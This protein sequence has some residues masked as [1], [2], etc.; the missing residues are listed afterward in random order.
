MAN[1]IADEQGAGSSGVGSG[2]TFGSNPED[3][4]VLLSREIPGRRVERAS[5][6]PVS[7]LKSLHDVTDRAKKDLYEA[8]YIDLGLT[9]NH[10]FSGSPMRCPA[11]MIGGTTTD[12]DFVGSWA[13]V[14][15]GEPTQGKAYFLVQ[16]RGTTVPRG[17][18]RSV[19]TAWALRAARPTLSRHTHQRLF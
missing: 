14:N 4:S 18:K 11:R 2:S 6:L 8:T 10:L 12:A 19:S 3:P 5:V 9:I 16:G 7:P 15:R 13:L 1:A 17:H